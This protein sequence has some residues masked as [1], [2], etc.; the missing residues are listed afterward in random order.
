MVE[1]TSRRFHIV[2]DAVGCDSNL[3]NSKVAIEKLITNLADL[4]SM[5]ILKGPIVAD[6][7]PENPGISAF[8]IIDFSHI[9]IHTFTH[10]NEFCLDVFSC[11]NFDFELVKK[12]I[13]KFFC[14]NNNQLNV[15][16]VRYEQFPIERMLNSFKPSEYLSEYYKKLNSENKKILSW[17]HKIYSDPNLK[18]AKLLEVGG[19]PTIYQLISAASVAGEIV[20]TDYLESNISEIKKWKSDKGSAFKWDNFI[21]YVLRLEKLSPE[22]LPRRSELIKNKISKILKLNLNELDE[23]YAAKFDVVQSNFCAESATDDI[24]EYKNML[25]NISSYL[26][27]GGVLLMTALEGSIVYRSAKKYFPVIYLDEELV[28]EYLKEAGFKINTI[29]KIFSDNPVL[30]KYHGILLIKAEKQ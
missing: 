20:F 8:A 19:G 22:E 15:S 26:K 9:A 29:E 24:T 1:S 23:S 6:G 7:I 4:V 13:K 17:Y 27:K 14:L 11:R 21:N 16:V 18:G 28:Q 3:L 5:K 25:R 12:Y 10:T 2:L 30:S